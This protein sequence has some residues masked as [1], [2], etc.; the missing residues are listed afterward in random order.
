[1]STNYTGQTPGE[2]VQSFGKR[3]LYG[4]KRTDQG[5]L[6]F[7]KLDQMQP[8]SS[9]A[10]NMPGDPED[11]FD[12]LEEGQ[13]FFEGRDNTHKKVFE[14]LNYEQFKW[15]NRNIMYYVDADGQ[16][17]ARVNRNYTYDPLSASDSEEDY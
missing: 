14:N 1:M 3:Y 9:L 6:W 10:I 2:I 13:N 7:G 11:N 5:E 15:D 17:V 4:L 16:L 12:N 8:D